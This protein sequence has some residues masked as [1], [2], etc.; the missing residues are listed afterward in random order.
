MNDAFLAPTADTVQ[1]IPV[2]LN[3]KAP[4]PTGVQIGEFVIHE[5]HR[6]DQYSRYIFPAFVDRALEFIKKYQSETDPVWLQ[7][8]LYNAFQH[9]LESVKLLCAVDSKNNIV[10]HVI[11]YVD[12]YGTRGSVAFI[13]QVEKDLT[14]PEIM[15]EGF[16]ILVAWKEKHKLNGMMHFALNEKVARVFQMEYGFKTHRIIQVRE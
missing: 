1:S 11:A 2:S 16:K 6:T 3:G 4:T 8:L 15:D 5:I 9:D 14:N 13:C 7:Q 12:Q 10:A